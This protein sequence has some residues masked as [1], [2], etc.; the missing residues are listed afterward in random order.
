[1][2]EESK[3]FEKE[4]YEQQFKIEEIWTKENIDKDENK[5]EE[6]IKNVEGTGKIQVE[7]IQIP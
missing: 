2:E 4:L 5:V 7:K 3:R 1:M 6:E